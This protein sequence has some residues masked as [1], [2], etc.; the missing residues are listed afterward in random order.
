MDKL[1]ELLRSRKFWAAVVGLAFVLIDAFVPSFPLT[2]DQITDIVMI[3][4]AY[5][6]GSGVQ[7][8]LERQGGRAAE[9]RAEVK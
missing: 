5:I 4:A 7:A 6:L 3:L 8:G 9:A 2:A 1:L